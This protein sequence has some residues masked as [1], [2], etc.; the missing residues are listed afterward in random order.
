[1]NYKVYAMQYTKP[2]CSN[3]PVCSVGFM[4]SEAEHRTM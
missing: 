4:R 2:R 3:C 1:M